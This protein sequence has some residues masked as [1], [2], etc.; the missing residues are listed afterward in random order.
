MQIGQM[1]AESCEERHTRRVDA[2]LTYVYIHLT[3]VFQNPVSARVLWGRACQ[4]NPSLNTFPPGACVSGQRKDNQVLQGT[5]RST[6]KKKQSRT[7]PLSRASPFPVRA[8][9]CSTSFAVYIFLRYIYFPYKYFN[10][11]YMKGFCFPLYCCIYSNIVCA[12]VCV[13]VRLAPTTPPCVIVVSLLTCLFVCVF[14]PRTCVCMEGYC[15]PRY[16]CISF[17]ILCACVCVCVCFSPETPPC[18]IVVFLSTYL[19]VCVSLY[20]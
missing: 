3:Y 15:F 14:L 2:V 9:S 17:N 20:I 13:C 4:G 12:R 7:R 6:V 10:T 1:R 18:V 16:C 11:Q 5:S 19:C 8:E